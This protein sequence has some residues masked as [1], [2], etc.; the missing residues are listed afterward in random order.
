MTGRRSRDALS[1]GL[2][3]IGRA[4]IC[5]GP[6]SHVRAFDTTTDQF[7]TYGPHERAAVL[8]EVGMFLTGLVAERP[9]WPGGGLLPPITAGDAS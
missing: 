1:L 4:L 6:N 3:E 5:V 7:I 8:A 9:F 2:P